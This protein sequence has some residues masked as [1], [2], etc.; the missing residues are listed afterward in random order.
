LFKDILSTLGVVDIPKAGLGL[1]AAGVVRR[2]GS[3]VENIAVGDRVL[4]FGGGAFS[5]LVKTP[6]VLCSKMPPQLSF[7]DAS[8]MPCVFGTVIHCLEDVGRLEK[9]QVSRT[10]ALTLTGLMVAGA[11]QVITVDFDP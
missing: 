8:T 1:E 10:H 2:I 3:R 4:L 7:E 11:K 5:S 6:A 9:D